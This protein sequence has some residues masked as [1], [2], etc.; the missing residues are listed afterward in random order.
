MEMTRSVRW[1]GSRSPSR[2]IQEK[3]TLRSTAALSCESLG[4]NIRTSKIRPEIAALNGGGG[5]F[6][7]IEDATGNGGADF[8]DK[9]LRQLDGW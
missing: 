6:I 1:L 2:G 9:P 5:Q 3:V 8:C 7:F 4:I